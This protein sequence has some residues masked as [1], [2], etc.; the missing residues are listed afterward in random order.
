M[1]EKEHPRRGS[2]AH[3]PRKRAPSQKPRVRSW[4]EE[5]EVG[6]LG[7]AGYKAGMTHV[8][9]VDDHPGRVTEGQEI[10]V[11]VTVL[12]VPPIKVCGIRIYGKDFEG[13]K[14]LTEVWDEYFSE[15]LSRLVKVP[16]DYDQDEALENAEKFI[17]EGDLE[18]IVVLIHTQPSLASLP[19]KKPELMELQLGG[20]SIK[21]KWEYAKEIL[22]NEIKFSETFSEGNY[23]DVF[24]I[25]KGKGTEGPVQRWGVKVQPH[26]VQQ[27]RKHTG[28]LGPWRP[29]RIMRTVPMTGQEGYHQ[30]MEYNKRILKMGENGEEVTPEGGFLRFGEIENEFVILKGSVP[31]PTK[32]MIFFRKPMRK[33]EGL[34]TSPPTINYIDTSSHQGGS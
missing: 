7:F 31:G 8:F 1:P 14:A 32:R 19:K 12:E 18:E 23:T 5:G 16:E 15:D 24:A 9:M 4:P 17:E 2:L 27:A 13:E 22:G 30:R 21:E 33:K 11:P 25:T 34:P 20:N 10:N 3:A 26:K 6:L 28:V 29:S